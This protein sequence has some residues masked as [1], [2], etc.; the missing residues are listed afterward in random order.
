MDELRDQIRDVLTAEGVNKEFFAWLD[1][2][3][4]DAKIR[5]LE[6]GLK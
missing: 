4:S 1:Q 2:Q 6:T 5:Y 3:R